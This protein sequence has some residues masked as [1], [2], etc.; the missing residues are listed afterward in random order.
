MMHVV[1][2]LGKSVP[3]LVQISESV[4]GDVLRPGLDALFHGALQHVRPAVAMTD[5]DVG[6]GNLLESVFGASL[7]VLWCRFHVLQGFFRAMRKATDVPQNVRDAVRGHLCKALDAETEEGVKTAVGKACAAAKGHRA[8]E[9]WLPF[10]VKRVERWAEFYR[11]H[12][13]TNSRRTNNPA[14]IVHRVWVHLYKT[15]RG[16][17]LLSAVMTM[18]NSERLDYNWRHSEE[19]AEC[20]LSSFLFDLIR[21]QVKKQS[22]DEESDAVQPGTPCHC[23]FAR[24]YG[25]IPCRHCPSDYKEKLLSSSTRSEMFAVLLRQ[26]VPIPTHLQLDGVASAEEDKQA[27][28]NDIDIVCV[29]PSAL[30]DAETTYH[31]VGAHGVGNDDRER[32][33]IARERRTHYAPPPA[34]VETT[35]SRRAKRRL[36]SPASAEDSSPKLGSVNVADTRYAFECLQATLSRV[37][38]RGDAVELGS[39]DFELVSGVVNI[40]EE[41]QLAAKLKELFL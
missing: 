7:R 41:T 10:W 14:E 4:A 20:P 24:Q 13:P 9:D 28:E 35:T 16:L 30:L 12:L 34:R 31:D 6:E 22:E 18:V 1:D 32:R 3:I 36:L 2:S 39:D 25:L 19:L 8:L 17:D 33:L 38:G 37:Y 40:V 15:T 27:L 23:Q 29:K 5:C 21:K 11:R 26:H